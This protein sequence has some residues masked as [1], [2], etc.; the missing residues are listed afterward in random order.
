MFDIK[1]ITMEDGLKT[2]GFI[3]VSLV[4]LEIFLPVFV[5]SFEDYLDN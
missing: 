2:L 1:E 4:L 5:R 3:I